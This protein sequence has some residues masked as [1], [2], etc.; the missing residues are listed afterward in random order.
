MGPLDYRGTGTVAIKRHFGLDSRLLRVEI[1]VLM[2]SVTVA[3]QGPRAPVR[4]DDLNLKMAPIHSSPKRGAS[5][6]LNLCPAAYNM[7]R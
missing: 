6:L 5:G 3:D 1:S 2:A 7:T 4:S